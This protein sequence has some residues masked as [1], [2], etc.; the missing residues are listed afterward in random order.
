MSK[1]LQL[2]DIV[3]SNINQQ[4][5]F[6]VDSANNFPSGLQM[7]YVCDLPDDGNP[8]VCFRPYKN[9][10][11]LILDKETEK[12][13]KASQSGSHF[14]CLKGG[15]LTK[16][17]I[18]DVREFGKNYGNPWVPGGSMTKEVNIWLYESDAPSAYERVTPAQA[19]KLYPQIKQQLADLTSDK[20]ELSCSADNEALKLERAKTLKM[21]LRFE[22]V[23]KGHVTG[24]YGWVTIHDVNYSRSFHSRD[25]FVEWITAN[26]VTDITDTEYRVGY[27]TFR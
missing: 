5:Q 8:H 12:V 14:Q 13:A 23:Y 22:L 1:T 2:G 4:K 11:T 10:T 24:D 26:E 15:T 19:V 16:L 25:E 7:G 27:L 21:S 3:I 17:P 9:S 20:R 18:N 6:M